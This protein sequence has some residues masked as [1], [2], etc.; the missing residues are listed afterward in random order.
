MRAGK[1]GAVDVEEEDKDEEEGTV[2]FDEEESA[3]GADG[4]TSVMDVTVAVFAF[5]G[6]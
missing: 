5:S 6:A 2:E 4:G 1:A 3:R